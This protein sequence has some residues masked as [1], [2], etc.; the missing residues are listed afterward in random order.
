MLDNTLVLRVTEIQ[1]PPAHLQ[2][3]MTF[4]I[5]GGKNAGIRSGRW[6]KVRSQPH[7]NMLVTLLNLFGGTDKTFGNSKYRTGMLRGL[8]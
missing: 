4:L 6:L 8:T 2:T 5:A 3:K 1:E 7:N